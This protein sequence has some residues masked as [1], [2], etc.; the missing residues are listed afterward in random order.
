MNNLIKKLIKEG[1]LTED[2]ADYI[3]EMYN[4]YRINYNYLS[5]NAE[6]WDYIFVKLIN[7]YFIRT[8]FI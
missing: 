7:S 3:Y 1:K 2:N 5:I 6:A 8:N 4:N